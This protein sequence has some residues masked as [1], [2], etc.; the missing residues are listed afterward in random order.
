MSGCID[1]AKRNFSHN[2]PKTLRILSY[3]FG[4]DEVSPKSKMKLAVIIF[5]VRVIFAKGRMSKMYLAVW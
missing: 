5:N 4:F 2:I 3:D 1:N